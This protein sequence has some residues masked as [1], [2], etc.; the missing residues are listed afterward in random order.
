[1]AISPQPA[2]LADEIIKRLTYTT[3]IEID[4][5][6][7]KKYY[8]ALQKIKKE[9]FIDSKDYIALGMV[10][11]NLRK[12]ND[13]L[14][15]MENGIK[16]LNSVDILESYVIGKLFLIS[17]GLV[18]SRT[19]NIS[20]EWFNHVLNKN[21]KPLNINFNVDQIVLCNK[22]FSLQKNVIGKIDICADGLCKIQL[23]PFYVDVFYN[24]IV[25]ENFNFFMPV[26]DGFFKKYINNNLKKA[27]KDFFIEIFGKIQYLEITEIIHKE[28]EEDIQDALEMEKMIYGKGYEGLKKYCEIQTTGV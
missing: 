9:N 14:K 1:M 12:Y 10:L 22:I 23:G 8:L 5:F 20:K 11:F 2:R 6:T 17:R 18:K 13:F 15:T 4:E 16:Y 27:E 24:K 19:F 26:F 25:E 7:L 28:E 3:R 21:T